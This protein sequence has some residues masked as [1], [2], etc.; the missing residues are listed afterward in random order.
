[1]A[2]SAPKSET[3][4]ATS[5]SA[6]AIYV[7]AY[8]RSEAAASFGRESSFLADFDGPTVPTV[9]RR[10]LAEV[11]ND[12]RRGCGGSIGRCSRRWVRD[13]R[14]SAAQ[15]VSGCPSNEANRAWKA[16]WTI[17]LRAIRTSWFGFDDT[18]FFISFFRADIIFQC[19]LVRVKD[20]DCFL[21]K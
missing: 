13:G 5:A 20:G 2:E 17:H 21:R 15:S 18:Y 4:A 8:Q 7:F 10:P 9:E 6:T 1:L 12:D 14:L 16:V 11:A 3:S 19:L